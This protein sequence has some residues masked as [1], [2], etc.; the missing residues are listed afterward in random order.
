MDPSDR[1]LEVTPLE[2]VELLANSASPAAVGDSNPMNTPR[3]PLARLGPAFL[4]VGYVDGD[5]A[6]PTLA[7]VGRDHRAEQLLGSRDVRGVGP[8]QIVVHQQDPF[9]RMVLSS[10]ITLAIGRCR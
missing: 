3:Q 2:Q 7:Q 5:L 9:L 8:D 10:S 4:V 1:G 6:D